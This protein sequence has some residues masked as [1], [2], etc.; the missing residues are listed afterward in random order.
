MKLTLDEQ[1]IKSISFFQNLTGSSVIDCISE[2]GDL[3][4]VVASGHYGLSVGKGGSKI[5]NAEK[6]FKKN[7]RIFEYSPDMKQ[8]IKNMVPEAQEIAVKKQT[9]DQGSPSSSCVEIKIKP[10]DRTRV[11]GRGGKNIKIMNRFLERLFG[12]AAMRVR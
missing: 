9:G 11:I 10:Q 7:I 6:I 2:N 8:F 5:R 4:F 3:Y 12:V 1:A